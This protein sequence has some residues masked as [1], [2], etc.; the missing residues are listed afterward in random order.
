VEPAAREVHEKDVEQL[1]GRVAP[2]PRDTVGILLLKAGEEL[3][4]LEEQDDERTVDRQVELFAFLSAQVLPSLSRFQNWNAYSS[5]LV[6][7]LATK[8]R[9][10]GGSLRRKRLAATRGPASAPAKSTYTNQFLTPE[11]A[12]IKAMR[13]HTAG[14]VRGAGRASDSTTRRAPRP[15]SSITA[16][17]TM[18]RCGQ[19]GDLR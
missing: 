8:T 5:Q 1:S 17:S 7:S 6:T 14:R 3:L 12:I 4:V 16:G 13:P 15:A 11:T 18:L 9:V 2:H 10:S 19:Y